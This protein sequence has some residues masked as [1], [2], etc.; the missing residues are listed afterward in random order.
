MDKIESEACNCIQTSEYIM[1]TY[2]M[3][4][5]LPADARKF[6]IDMVA[7][8]GFNETVSQLIACRDSAR[9]HGKHLSTQVYPMY[10]EGVRICNLCLDM[11]SMHGLL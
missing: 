5:C 8:H 2:D 7:F 3:L 1:S 10:W 11:L 6:Y 9:T 4:N